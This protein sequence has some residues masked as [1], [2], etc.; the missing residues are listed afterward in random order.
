MSVKKCTFQSHRWYCPIRGLRQ[1]YDFGLPIPHRDQK[2]PPA[3]LGCHRWPLADAHRLGS[4]ANNEPYTSGADVGV[5]FA[6]T[7]VIA[8]SPDEVP[9]LRNDPHTGKRPRVRWTSQKR[10]A[11]SKRPRR[12]C[13]S[14][15]RTRRPSV[16]QS[17]AV[18]ER[19]GRLDVLVSNGAVAYIKDDDGNLATGAGL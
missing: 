17:K 18:E 2:R 12:R 5:G 10:P 7:R 16:V 14:T 13:S 3:R 15:K 4:R 11:S 6:S 19:F 1:A 8:S 9:R